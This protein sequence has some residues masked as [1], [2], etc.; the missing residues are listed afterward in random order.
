[1]DILVVALS[2]EA[3]IY[4]STLALV[5]CSLSSYRSRVDDTWTKGGRS[6]ILTDRIMWPCRDRR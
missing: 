3:L 6:A 4:V 1:V 5:S 2:Q